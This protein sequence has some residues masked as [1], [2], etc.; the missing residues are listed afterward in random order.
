[1]T[2]RDLIEYYRSRAREYEN[3]YYRDIPRRRKEID[4]EVLYLRELVRGKSVLDLACGSGYWAEIMAQA[5]SFILAIDISMEMIDQA[6]RKQYESEVAF[7]LGDIEKIPAAGN[8]F[9]IVALGFWFSHQPRQ[10]YRQFFS[11]LLRLRKKNGLIWMIDNNPSTENP[12]QDLVRTD[13]HGNTYKRRI[14]ESG[15]QHVILKNYFTESQLRQTFAP[16]FT[17]RRFIYNYYYWSVVL[18]T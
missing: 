15:E 1:M 8:A 17:I 6:R 11:E 10:H 5:A 7:A 13:S 3:I 18:G 9:D 16:H 14:L 4:D 12:P 2:D